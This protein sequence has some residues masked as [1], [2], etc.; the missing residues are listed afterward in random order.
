MPK[1]Q[2]FTGN[3]SFTFFFSSDLIH[4]INKFSSFL[5]NPTFIDHVSLY[6]T[7][8][9]KICQAND[10]LH[11]RQF[12]QH[13][14]IDIKDMEYVLEILLRNQQVKLIILPT[15]ISDM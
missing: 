3:L 1:I 4:T 9:S 6:R 2:L 7:R 15:L 8:F 13:L 11:R 14:L 12:Y 10:L 5:E